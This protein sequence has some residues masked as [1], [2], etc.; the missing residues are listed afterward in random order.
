MQSIED[1]IISRIYGWGRGKVFTPN[2]FLTLGSR[3]AVDKALSRLTAQK[4]IRR[5]GRG[6]YDYPKAHPELGVLSPSPTAVAEAVAKSKSLRLIPSGAYAA[7]V[8]GLSEQVPMKIV[9]LTDAES[10]KV[11]I[12]KQTIELRKTTPR[13]LATANR[14]SG[15]VIQALKYMGEKHVDEG[16]I[17][18][19]R[20]V[21]PSPDKRILLK[22]KS[23]APEWM[24]SIIERV[25]QDK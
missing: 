22:D 2:D 21:L 6:L 25:S 16:A 5:L 14:P 4:M 11:K 7:N 1:K 17:R 20:R 9:F 12:G 13:N 19:L 24:R 3:L 18:H 8:L 15:I 23:Y 10:R